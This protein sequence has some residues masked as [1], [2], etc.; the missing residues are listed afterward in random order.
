MPVPPFGSI[1]EG[2]SLADMINEFAKIQKQLNYIMDGGLDST[3]AREFGGWLIDTDQ[4]VSLNG[5]VGFSSADT[6]VDDIRMWAGNVNT[7]IAAYRVYESG[8]L[9]C[10]D[11]DITGKITSGEG[12]IGGW[13]IGANFIMDALGMTGL[14]SLVT[15]GNDV[16][17]WA[18][19][20]D[21]SIAAFRVYEDGSAFASN[22]TLE[23]G[24][25]R[26][27]ASPGERIEIAANQLST[28]NASNQLEGLVLGYNSGGGSTYGD[29][30][31]FS[32][33]TR[34]ALFYNT[35]SDGWQ[36]MGDGGKAL[37]LGGSEG[38][39][40][41]GDWNFFGTVSGLITD[42][43]PNHNHGI[44]PGAQWLD[45]DGVTVHT[46]VASGGHSHVVS[47]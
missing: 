16:R 7:S 27:A 1:N 32:G 22:L 37:R 3:N 18:G 8:H 10:S 5:L 23:G 4:L 33:G 34:T 43:A 47:T 21:T 28:Y 45:I 26:S 44:A 12:I 31:L 19:N 6:G 15:G 24:V 14:S 11:V 39:Y 36:L 38:V 30:S 2:A 35:V 17:F 25:I 9:F 42:T 41:F 29:V 20:A 40:C 46:W 13:E